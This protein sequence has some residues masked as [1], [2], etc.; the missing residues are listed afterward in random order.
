MKNQIIR[1]LVKLEHIDNYLVFCSKMEDYTFLENSIQH[2]RLDLLLSQSSSSILIDTDQSSNISSPSSL[3]NTIHNETA[4]IT[5]LGEECNILDS[6][7]NINS[8][9]YFLLNPSRMENNKD[10]S[11]KNQEKLY[12]RPNM[13]PYYGE[14]L[15]LNSFNEPENKRNE[16]L[17]NSNSFENHK[18][19]KLINRE[20]FENTAVKQETST[21][22]T[23]I[24]LSG[25]KINTELTRKFRNTDLLN[26]VLQSDS[27]RKKLLDMTKKEQS[28]YCL[29]KPCDNNSTQRVAGEIE[30]FSNINLLESNAENICIFSESE[31]VRKVFEGQNDFLLPEDVNVNSKIKL[32][33]TANKTEQ[34]HVLKPIASEHALKNYKKVCM[35]II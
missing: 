27:K 32:E 34:T 17:S 15:I 35:P 3:P 7:S 26:S 13:N 33:Y 25:T 29:E 28:N 31:H 8:N 12:P 6:N 10:E 14:A 18:T 2:R 16:L 19:E 11:H 21:T 23:D 30:T 5:T 4:V 20:S 9:F 22:I 1:Y 24:I